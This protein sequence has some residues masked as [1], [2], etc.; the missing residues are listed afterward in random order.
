M[1]CQG[2][3]DI[4]GELSHARQAVVRLATGRDDLHALLNCDVNPS[5]VIDSLASGLE[6]GRRSTLLNQRRKL[7]IEPASSD[8]V[9][10]AV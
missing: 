4:F 7:S 8:L 5:R 2:N 3:G 10:K 6:S 9:V 1:E